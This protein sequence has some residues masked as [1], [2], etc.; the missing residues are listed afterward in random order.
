MVFRSLSLLSLVNGSESILLIQCRYAAGLCSVGWL[1]PKFMVVSVAV[2][3]LNMSVS[4][5]GVL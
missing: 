3:F 1:E 2:G 5:L 4:N